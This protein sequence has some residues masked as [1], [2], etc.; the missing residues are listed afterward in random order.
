IDHVA[1][2][3]VRSLDEA[4]LLGGGI[5]I[6]IRLLRGDRRWFHHRDWYGAIGF[7]IAGLISSAL[8]G[9]AAPAALGLILSCKFFGFI[10][11]AVPGQKGDDER[12]L[13]V[14]IWVTPLL[15]LV[16][17]AGFVDPSWVLR[18]VAR[19]ET[20]DDFMRGGIVPAMA[21]LPHPGVFAWAMAVGI[22]AAAT[23]L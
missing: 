8:H 14:A 18:Y 13:S 21:P 5:F 3:V 9:Q 1:A 10:L 11:L 12:L 19:D 2:G 15:F 6:A 22:L 20:H 16:G 4:A 23:H 17:F 7:L